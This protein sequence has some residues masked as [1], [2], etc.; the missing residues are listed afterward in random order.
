[1]KKEHNVERFFCV[2]AGCGVS[3][4]TAADIKHHYKEA[5]TGKQR[6]PE[7][8][9]KWNRPE[10]HYNRAHQ[11][12]Q[13]VATGRKDHLPPREAHTSDRGTKRPES[14]R[15][16][17]PNGKQQETNRGGGRYDGTENRR[18]VKRKDPRGKNTTNQRRIQKDFQKKFHK[19]LKEL[20][21][22]EKALSGDDEPME[23]TQEDT[24]PLGPR[25]L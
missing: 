20:K 8:L 4:R 19:A 9:G 16:T 6:D 12:N 3:R 17:S 10:G 18:G 1:M 11:G 2:I 13:K 14:G 5:H 21:A 25:G 22:E 7:E 24:Q 15:E 23:E